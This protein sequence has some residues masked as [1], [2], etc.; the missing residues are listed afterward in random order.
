MGLWVV[1]GLQGDR[2]E[3]AFLRL[4]GAIYPRLNWEKGVP[5]SPSG[6]V[7]WAV[8]SWGQSGGVEYCERLAMAKMK[9]QDERA[10]DVLITI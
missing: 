7:C 9:M 4:A 10:M 3:L 1:L 8:C 6:R 2:A 5:L